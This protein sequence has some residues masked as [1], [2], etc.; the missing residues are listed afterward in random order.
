MR[1]DPNNITFWRITE[2]GDEE[3]VELPSRYEVCGRCRGRGAHVNEAIDGHGISGD[4]ECWQ[5]D[6]FTEMYFSGGYD[7]VCTECNGR[8][9]VAVPDEKACDPELLA[10]YHEYLH[11]MWEDRQMS[12]M[13]RRMGA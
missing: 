1:G 12:A 4:D 9:V 6:Q 2:S 10:A 8:N 11:D 3:L 5:D 13:E 7:V